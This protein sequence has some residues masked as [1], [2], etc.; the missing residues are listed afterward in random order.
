MHIHFMSYKEQLN[1][2]TIYQSI[3]ILSFESK[4]RYHYIYNGISCHML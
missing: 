4:D 3:K 1:D 2:L